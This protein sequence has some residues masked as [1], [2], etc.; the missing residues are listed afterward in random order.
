MKHAVDMGGSEARNAL[1]QLEGLVLPRAEE[2]AELAKAIHEA[3]DED[4]IVDI[5]AKLGSRPVSDATADPAAITALE[6]EPPP[7]PEGAVPAATES[8]P[9]PE[10]TSE[11]TPA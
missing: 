8:A 4:T 5:L 2:D 6:T 1:V 10:A 11:T 9:A 7:A 3:G